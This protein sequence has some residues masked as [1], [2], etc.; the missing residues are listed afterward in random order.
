MNKDKLMEQWDTKNSIDRMALD[1]VRKGNQNDFFEKAEYVL[2]LACCY[3]VRQCFSSTDHYNLT[4]V[5]EIVNSSISHL[6]SLFEELRSNI[7]KMDLK[8]T[9]Y[10]SLAIKQYQ[11]FVDSTKSRETV[12][13]SV[14]L[15]LQKYLNP[16]SKVA[17]SKGN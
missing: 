15:Q 11:L 5:Q 7:V 4:M 9:Y 13:L 6:D 1:I 17:T 14:R 16:C 10:G 8:E 3:Y 2:L 12:L